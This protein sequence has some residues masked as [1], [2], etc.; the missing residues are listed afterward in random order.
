M[1]PN[2]E[3][4]KKIFEWGIKPVVCNQV[5][6]LIDEIAREKKLSSGVIVPQALEDATD[7]RMATVI[8]VGADVT[9]VKSGDRVVV[10]KYYGI[11]IPHEDNNICKLVVISDDQIDAILEDGQVIG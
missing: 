11:A 4:I 7:I 3:V 1:G 10:G 5:I 6:L 8:N 9:V 2:K